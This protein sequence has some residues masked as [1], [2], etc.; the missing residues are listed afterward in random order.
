MLELNEIHNPFPGLRPFEMD[1]TNLFFGRDG[2]SDELL[3]RMQ[4]ARLLAV[5][6]TSGSGKSSLIRAG[7]LPALYGG[8]M[9]DAG[10]SWRIAIQRPGGDPIGN[11]A[12]ALADR[13]VFGTEGDSDIQIAMLE[14]TLR[15]S[16]IGLIDVAREARMPQHENLLVV[17]DQF[18]ELFRFKESQ[19]GDDATAFVKLL[20][21]A[22]A[23]QEIPIYIIITMRSDFLGDCSQFTGLPEAINNGQY[24]IPRMSRDERQSAIVGPIAVGEGQISAPLVS[25]L[26]NDVGDNPDQL[27]ILQHA[28]MRTWDYW[29]AHRLNGDAI[30]LE[31]YTAIG[32]MAE[33][34]SR[35]A[36]EAFNELPDD[37]H[38]EIAEKLFKRLTEKGTDNRE[39]RRPT[40]LAELSAVCEATEDDIKTIIEVFRREGRSFLM[41]PVG[42]KLTSETVIDISHESLIR[43]WLRL[44]KWVD[45]E[46]QSSRTYRRLAEAA[47]L[48]REGSEDL[49]R[50]PA[51]QIALDWFEKSR[52]NDAWAKR[53]H[54]EFAAATQYLTASCER[55]EEA[56]REREQQRNAELERERREREQAELYAEEQR[57]A[58]RRLRRFSFALVLISVLALAAAGGAV[59][60]FAMAKT[61]E[62]KAQASQKNAQESEK[63]ARADKLKAEAA[64]RDAERLATQLQENEKKLLKASDE[65]KDSV[66]LAQAAEER[67]QIEADNAR[68]REKEALAA[69]QL[70]LEAK[71]TAEVAEGLAKGNARRGEL[72]QDAL[73]SLQRKEY[74]LALDS[75]GK[76]VTSVE[77]AL[78]DPKVPEL[79][80]QRLTIEK[81]W[82]RAHEGSAWLGQQD[83][84][85]AATSYEDAR[86]VLE[87]VWPK[88]IRDP[89]DPDPILYETYVG[90]GKTYQL[91]GLDVV[92][93]PQQV[94]PGLYFTKAETLFQDALKYHEAQLER[95]N[96][97]PDEQR[98]PVE[99]RA[100]IEGHLNLARLYR[101]MGKTEQAEQQFLALIEKLPLVHTT[102]LAQARR[103][104]AEFYRDQSKYGEAVAAYK[105]LILQQ[106][107]T[108]FDDLGSFRSEAPAELIEANFARDGQE[109]ANSYNELADAYRGWADT[110]AD[111]AKADEMSARADAAFGLSVAL[112]RFAVRMRRYLASSDP[113]A[114]T[115]R[116]DL[117]DNLGDAFLKFDKGPRAVLFYQYALDVRKGGNSAADRLQVG[118]SYD[119]LG[120]FY[121]SKRDYAKAEQNYNDQVAFYQSNPQSAEYAK[122]V[123]DL[124]ALYGDDPKAAPEL[125]VTKYREA[126][127]LYRSL[128]DWSGEDVVLYRL[129]KLYEKRQQPEARLGALQE[130]VAALAPYYDQLISGTFKNLD[131]GPKLISEYL[132]SINVLGYVL[133]QDNQAA[134]SEAVYQRAWAMRTYL[135]TNIKFMKDANTKSLYD[136]ML[137]E[138]QHL[139]SLQQKTGLVN[140]VRDFR[141]SL[142]RTDER[143]R[144]VQASA[145]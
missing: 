10:S 57:K 128:N 44:Q 74:G 47:V 127:S 5:V 6:G 32:T 77:E 43:N 125:A 132:Q 61:N 105:N 101:D 138:Y 33:A 22:S 48:H 91:L 130:R 56:Q 67:A 37:R 39:I 70:A 62:R 100:V 40:T 98:Q 19:T 139:L 122:A 28:L 63:N 54:P 78:E 85:K 99:V 59:V 94:S 14:T 26:L 110:A 114:P 69:K 72:S 137:A 97:R 4:R 36:D 93:G 113:S 7:L 55:R 141:D 73:E 140:E 35:H 103:E 107:E 51:L 60:G 25:R 53:Y 108:A 27:P 124:A 102:E 15:R 52:P 87:K 38:R 136:A 131:E 42:T 49:L 120:N 90:L 2:Q 142:N 119:K 31:D 88:E 118:K 80:K 89:Q 68:S 71:T 45:D 23:Q 16:S 106:E 34:L 46:A 123:R 20:L 65:L 135:S 117:A 84:S 116:D 66:K 129:T 82:T 95:L 21:E 109:I 76:L 11:L 121:R 29:S 126:L 58:A 41:P 64:Q 134:R 111:K 30:G 144:V 13:Q 24:L 115:D 143:N 17:V 3:K 1:E 79:E 75:L 50:D 8:L 145:K 112:D 18:E 96:T 9:G 81:G 86:G 133:A 92:A 104:F 83:V 12:A